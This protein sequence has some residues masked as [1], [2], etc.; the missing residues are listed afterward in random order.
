MGP[1]PF[2]HGYRL[3]ERIAVV[4]V[5]ASMGP[6]PFRHGYV[7]DG[8]LV[9]VPPVRLQWGHA[10]SGMD[11]CPTCG[12]HYFVSMLQWGHA[13]S[14]MDTRCYSS[15]VALLCRLQWGHA[16]SGMDTG[17]W[18]IVDSVGA[19]LLQWGHALSGMDTFSDWWNGTIDDGFN[20]A[21][22]FQ[23]WIH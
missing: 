15:Y 4:F 1:C 12:G 20:G 11:T 21:M 10:L 2:R 8:L 7:L 6:C 13:L 18:G 9:V 17:W 3:D 22:P 23:A 14:G 16:L 5:E 19:I